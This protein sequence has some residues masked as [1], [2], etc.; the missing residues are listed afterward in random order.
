MQ[1]CDRSSITAKQY[2]LP[3]S[4]FYRLTFTNSLNCAPTH[5]VHLHQYLWTIRLEEQTTLSVLLFAVNNDNV[6]ISEKQSHVRLT[7]YGS[8]SD[9]MTI[10]VKNSSLPEPNT[11]SL[12]TTTPENNNGNSVGY[13]FI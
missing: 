5:V 3:E 12:A 8:N 10:E 7:Q 13:A 6:P 2:C 1:S 4:T 11:T 9:K